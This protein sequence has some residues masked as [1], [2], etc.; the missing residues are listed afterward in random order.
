[1]STGVDEDGA[2]KAAAQRLLAKIRTFVA[3]QLD[4]DEAALFAALVAPG[5]A[6]AYEDDEDEV[7]GFGSDVDWRPGALP[8]SLA[9]AVRNGGIRVEG[10][11]DD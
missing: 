6:R 11:G 7:H 4:D 5:V 10:L 8:D 9:E 3:E 2:D 1:M